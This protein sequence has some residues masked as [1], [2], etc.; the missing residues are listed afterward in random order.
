MNGQEINTYKKN[1]RAGGEKCEAERYR[2][3]GCLQC[4]GKEHYP[5]TG[6]SVI[7]LIKLGIKTLLRNWQTHKERRGGSGF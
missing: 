1:K 5:T 4:V 7:L 3:S 6:L 2:S